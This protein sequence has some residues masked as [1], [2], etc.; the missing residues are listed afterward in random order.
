MH[1]LRVIALALLIIGGLNWGLVGLA[2]IDVFAAM[3]GAGSILARLTYVLF[4][5]AAFV[6]FAPLIDEASHGKM[7]PA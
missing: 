1:A 2:N 5:V 7:H 4:G 6:A 3:F